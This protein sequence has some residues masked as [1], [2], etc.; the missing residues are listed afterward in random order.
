MID[1]SI[2]KAYAIAATFKKRVKSSQDQ[3]G[4]AR[5][6]PKTAQGGPKTAQGGPKSPHSYR[7]VGSLRAL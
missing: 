3:P 1:T 6:G 4:M 5:N 7:K 2:G